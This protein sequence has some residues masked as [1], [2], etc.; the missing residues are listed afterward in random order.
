[1]H[2]LCYLLL[3]DA[4]SFEVYNASHLLALS[5]YSSVVTS[6]NTQLFGSVLTEE[7]KVVEAIFYDL[8]APH[9][10]T[11]RPTSSISTIIM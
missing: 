7:K 4:F 6:D 2:E 1:M 3:S 10:L 9:A 5:G 8:D 11:G